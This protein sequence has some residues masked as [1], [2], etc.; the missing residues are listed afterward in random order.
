MTE[1]F[2]RRVMKAR[3]QLLRRNMSEVERILWT[4][5]RRKQIDSLRFRR[6]YSVGAFV[7][8]F[9][10]PQIRFDVEVD[11]ES[12]NRPA[13]KEYDRERDEQLKSIGITVLRVTNEDVKSKLE[14]V[15][16]HIREAAASLK[17]TFPLIPLS[18]IPLIS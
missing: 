10:C 1:I 8:D 3:R 13:A 16:Q 2:N 15:L 12:H 18:R 17:T 5:L 6:Q 14:Y 4:K 7:F 9:Y 11:G